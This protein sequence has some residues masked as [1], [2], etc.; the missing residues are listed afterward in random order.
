MSVR[1]PAPSTA[2]LLPVASHWLSF[3]EACASEDAGADA[4]VR[5]PPGVLGRAIEQALEAPMA[6]DER[7][8]E[9]RR[10]EF[11]AGDDRSVRRQIEGGVRFPRLAALHRL[12]CGGKDPAQAFAIE[13]GA[14]CL[15]Q[16][17]AALRMLGTRV[18]VKEFEG[19]AFRLFDRG[20]E[21]LFPTALREGLAYAVG[22]PSIDWP[23]PA[24]IAYWVHPEPGLFCDR[25]RTSIVDHLGRD[26][27]AGGFLAIQSDILRRRNFQ[28]DPARWEE[29]FFRLIDGL[30]F[31]TT[32]WDMD[33][34]LIVLRR[35]D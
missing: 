33:A 19:P 23:I 2:A 10:M 25:D 28:P 16:T 15:V 20:V 1:T 14:G 6:V 8:R 34:A 31:P 9:S 35:R 26:V 18:L 11:R 29:I 21:R 17:T 12:L 7:G 4:A 13:N 3:A 22:K 30:V 32:I 27:V 5:E 24:D